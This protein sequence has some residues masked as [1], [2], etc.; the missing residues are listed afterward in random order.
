MQHASGAV[1]NIR[2]Y[3]FMWYNV[4]HF[5][6]RLR[7]TWLYA[8]YDFMQQ[9][10]FCNIKSFV[11]YLHRCAISHSYVS[12]D[13]ISFICVTW[14]Y[15]MCRIAHSYVSHDSSIRVTRWCT[16]TCDMTHPYECWDWFI[17]VICHIRR[18]DVTY[19][20]MFCEWF[21]CMICL[22]DTLFRMDE[23]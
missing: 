21:I 4:Y 11:R 14:L 3:V 6:Q 20:Y 23:W 15:H 8:T 17:C 10:T 9:M 7:M 5:I 12:H 16:H 18:C 2:V 22:D 13:S 19:A 1:C